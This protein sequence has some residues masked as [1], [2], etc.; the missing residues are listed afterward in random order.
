MSARVT[1][2]P[3]ATVKRA[4]RRAIAIMGSEH[5]LARACGVSQ[6]SISKAKLTGKISPQLALAIHR[7]TKGSVAASE[8]RPD[9]W[10]RPEHVPC[11]D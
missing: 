10:S 5:R 3:T 9:L 4:T 1:T 11:T 6:T 7:A 8:L 2:Y